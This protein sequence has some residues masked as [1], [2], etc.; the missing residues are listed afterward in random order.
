[1]DAAA[2]DGAL[3]TVKDGVFRVLICEVPS[4]KVTVPVGVAAP[5]TVAVN[6]TACPTV[7]GLADEVSVVAVR[8]R[9]A[10]NL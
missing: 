4:R 5:L 2:S 10:R 7:D 6:V 9:T 8:V 3:I 1:M